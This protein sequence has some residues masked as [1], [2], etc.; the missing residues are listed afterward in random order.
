MTTPSIEII[1]KPKLPEEEYENL[2]NKFKKIQSSIN[3]ETQSSPSLRPNFTNDINRFKKNL[4]DIEKEYQKNNISTKEYIFSIQKAKNALI[5]TLDDKNIGKTIQVQQQTSRMAFQSLSKEMDNFKS[6]ISKKKFS[7]S[8]LLFRTD[9]REM[10]KKIKNFS[11]IFDSIQNKTKQQTDTFKKKT[12]GLYEILAKKEEDGI[13]KLKKL[14]LQG[15]VGTSVMSGAAMFAGKKAVNYA[16]DAVMQES[17]YM[18]NLSRMQKI[19][20]LDTQLLQKYVGIATRHAGMDKVEAIS[21]V[22]HLQSFIE[23]AR[24]FGE[25]NLRMFGLNG[26]PL[27]GNALDIVDKM[28]LTYN[29]ANPL[30]QEQMRTSLRDLDFDTKFIDILSIT[31]Q[32][33]DELAKKTKILTDSQIKQIVATDKAYHNLTQTLAETKQEFLTMP[34][35]ANALNELSLSIENNRDV[36]NDFAAEVINLTAT[37][38]NATGSF[39]KDMQQYNKNIQQYG[40][41]IGTKI[42][43]TIATY[44]SSSSTSEKFLAIAG[45]FLPASKTIDPHKTSTILKDATTE[46]ASAPRTQNIN[47]SFEIINH[48]NVSD[49]KDNNIGTKITQQ[50]ENSVKNMLNSSSEQLQRTFADLIK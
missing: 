18:R 8:S 17:E 48:V 44:D 22:E 37:L 10:N 47:Q 41:K 50:I 39:F 49:A 11:E 23:K 36:F 29:K 21:G 27:Q 25:G 7:L 45:L 15:L 6:E 24:T 9:K 12:E 42:G 34:A 3:K 26:I 14:S 35:T 31:K 33:F 19:R 30:H 16:Q 2:V 32:E 13:N 28:R 40:D 38:I 20:G 4:F 5:S 43:E 46:A 1:V